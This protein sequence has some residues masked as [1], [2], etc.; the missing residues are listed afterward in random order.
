M[1]RLDPRLETRPQARVLDQSLL[2]A[3]TADGFA[4]AQKLARAPLTANGGFASKRLTLGFP[5]RTVNQAAIVVPLHGPGGRVDLALSP[6]ALDALV[7]LLGQGATADSGRTVSLDA[8]EALLAGLLAP[9][10]CGQ[11]SRAR[12]ADTH[13]AERAS[14]AWA[15][16]GLENTE[17]PVLGSDSALNALCDRIAAKADRLVAAPLSFLKS[18]PL[19]QAA[20]G[21]AVE[22]L[23]G[24]VQLS[25]DER[26]ALE[27]GGGV[28]LDA[29][30][31]DGRTCIARR[32]VAVD[33][34][35]RVDD[36]LSGDRLLVRSGAVVRGLDDPALGS[37]APN[38][39]LLELVDG[40][41]IVATGHLVGTGQCDDPRLIFALDRS[42]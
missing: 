5:S 39:G 23:V 27:A 32:F 41:E 13:D 2:A 38:L 18:P 20:V 26:A 11:V 15:A 19:G 22:T 42:G 17:I 33:G 37:A 16:L 10:A 7:G 25:Q 24:T 4:L 21:V 12:L 1:N 31:P 9:L 29:H 35:W 36:C 6:S 14:K 30:W 8:L 3:W 34:Q 40:Q 28:F